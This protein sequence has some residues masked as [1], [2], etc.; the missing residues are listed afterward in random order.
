MASAPLPGEG[1]QREAGQERAPGCPVE[2]ETP[3]P[4]SVTSSRTTGSS[5]AQAPSGAQD[6]ACSLLVYRRRKERGCL[7]VARLLTAAGGRGQS[8]PGTKEALGEPGTSAQGWTDQQGREVA[9]VARQLCLS[10]RAGGHP[11][12]QAGAQAT[13]ALL[14]LP[15]RTGPAACSP[16][17]SWGK[18][19]EMLLL[20]TGTAEP[21]AAESK[22]VKTAVRGQVFG[23][24]SREEGTS[25]TL[26]EIGLRCF[27]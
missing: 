26:P 4:A 18:Q 27:S 6:A 25:I 17:E 20:R 23:Q 13:P 21:P 24:D 1:S 5:L 22:R 9:R 10:I 2:A 12:R 14:L 16:A 3:H 7:P 8:G 19:K 15:L 11:S